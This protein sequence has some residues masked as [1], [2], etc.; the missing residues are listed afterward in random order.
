HVFVGLSEKGAGLGMPQ[1]HIGNPDGLEHVHGNLGSECALVLPMRVLGADFDGRAFQYAANPIQREISW[2][3]HDF[4]FVREDLAFNGFGQFHGK[5]GGIL[6]RLVHFPVAGDDFLAHGSGLFGESV[7]T[8]KGFPFQEFQG[9]AA[10]RGNMGDLIGQSE[11]FDGGG[12]IAPAD[13]GDG[14]FGSGL[15]QGFGHSE[16]AGRALLD[17]EYAHGSVPN[18]GLG[19]GD[20]GG[21]ELGRLGTDIDGFHIR[22]NAVLIHRFEIAQLPAFEIEA[23]RGHEVD[24]QLDFFAAAGEQGFGKVNLVV[25]AQGFADFESL[26]LQEG[27]RHT[28]SDEQFVHLGKHGFDYVDFARNLGSPDDGDKGTLGLIQS[29]AQEV[30]FLL[31]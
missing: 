22:G 29:S 18:H 8:W 4:S 27:V 20:D 24:G 23:V 25:F 19:P 16:G 5:L 1:N 28:A 9:G 31:H 10:A 12:G 11:L 3:D 14:A 7:Y 26:G 6:H 17:F 2:T 13:D 21:I 15:H 30:E